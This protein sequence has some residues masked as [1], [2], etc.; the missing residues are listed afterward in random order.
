MR[1]FGEELREKKTGWWLS[2]NW[3]ERTA[4]RK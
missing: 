2:L 1:K 3:R 4:E